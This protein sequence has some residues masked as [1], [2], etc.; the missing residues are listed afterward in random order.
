MEY[1]KD[2]FV[3]TNFGG[4]KFLYDQLK[5][6]KSLISN[7]NF[8]SNHF[9]IK[10]SKKS[11]LYKRFLDVKEEQDGNCLSVN[12]IEVLCVVFISTVHTSFYLILMENILKLSDKFEYITEYASYIE[13]ISDKDHLQFNMSI[14][15]RKYYA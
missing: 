8:K 12:G 4:R 13:S 11:E 5:F 9:K 15:K 6:K 10:I 14:P 3:L 2:D 1:K 7:F